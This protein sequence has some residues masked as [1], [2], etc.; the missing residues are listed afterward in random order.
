MKQR[1]LNVQT[2]HVQ[3]K[4]YNVG[5]YIRLS[6]ESTA[7]IDKDS[8]SIENQQTMMSKFIAMMPGWIEKRIYIE[9]YCL[10]LIQITY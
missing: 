2:P 6:R 4:L 5:M 8:M 10:S 9:T 7:Y 1:N 3:H